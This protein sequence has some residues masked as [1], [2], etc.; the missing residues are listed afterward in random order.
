MQHLIS[1]VNIFKKSINC[2]LFDLTCF[3]SRSSG[4]LVIT[5]EIICFIRLRKIDKRAGPYFGRGAH[6]V[7]PSPTY[8]IQRRWV[9]NFKFH[10]GLFKFALA[11]CI[12][13]N[14]IDTK[15]YIYDPG[16]FGISSFVLDLSK[17]H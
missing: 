2:A 10:R 15:E 3:N 4:G 1:H 5:S 8:S 6:F 12:F 16:F 17:T 7:R 11:S 9:L 14:E 13:N